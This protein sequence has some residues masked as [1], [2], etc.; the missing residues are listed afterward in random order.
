MEKPAP[1]SKYDEPL[2]THRGKPPAAYLRLS[3]GSSR[4]NSLEE[5]KL[6]VESN[7]SDD[8][9][10]VERL[11]EIE[12]QVTILAH[13]QLRN[14]DVTIPQ[15]ARM[16]NFELL[17]Q[18]YNEARALLNDIEQK[19]QEYIERKRREMVLSSRYSLPATATLISPESEPDF[20]EEAIL[21]AM[22]SSDPGI[23]IS[24]TKNRASETCK[25]YS[26][27]HHVLLVKYLSDVLDEP[28]HEHSYV[29]WPHVSFR[30]NKKVGAC[31]EMHHLDLS[32]YC[33]VIDGRIDISN[34]SLKAIRM[35]R[36]QIFTQFG[37]AKV[38]ACDMIV[39]DLS[40]PI[41]AGL[42]KQLFNSVYEHYAKIL[43]DY[44]ISGIKICYGGRR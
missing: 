31:V 3:S 17:E 39:I 34:P 27:K 9:H 10:H 32:G 7:I 38:L 33:M 36:R 26:S 44:G 14:D 20:D 6:S 11:H 19:E 16:G 5:G 37:I 18:I 22:K 24:Y 41:P 35:L 23:K 4:A 13:H 30:T 43:T 28:E 40:T 15:E 1:E 21:A 42:S 12:R 25:K 2:Q 8:R 29:T